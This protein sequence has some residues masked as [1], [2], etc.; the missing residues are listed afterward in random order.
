[1]CIPGHWINVCCKEKHDREK[2]K[3]TN[4]IQVESEG[5]YEPVLLIFINSLVL[6]GNQLQK[7]IYLNKD[8]VMIADST[9]GAW[10]IDTSVNSQMT[11]EVSA[12]T[13]LKTFMQGTIHFGD[14]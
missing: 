3:Q 14:A 12:F 1:M 9:D 2:Q 10:Y 6:V 8:K 7:R 13:T 11:S 4:L 5:D